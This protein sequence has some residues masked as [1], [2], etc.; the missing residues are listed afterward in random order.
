M[1]KL[2]KAAWEGQLYPE[3]TKISS[4]VVFF[5]NKTSLLI[6]YKKHYTQIVRT[7]CGEAQQTVMNSK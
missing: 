7:R 2:A 1:G 6:Y 3:G 4:M 5:S